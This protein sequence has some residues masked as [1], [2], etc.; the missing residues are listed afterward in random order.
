MHLSW[1][2]AALVGSLH[3]LLTSRQP[4]IRT[5]KFLLRPNTT[6]LRIDTFVVLLT[7]LLALNL[8]PVLLRPGDFIQDDSYFYLQ[9]ASHIV[10]GHGSTFHEITPTNGYHPLWM[11]CVV[12]MT[13]L[14]GGDNVWAVYLVVFLA[15]LLIAATLLLFRRLADEM[16][17][18]FWLPGLVVFASYLLGTGLYASEAHLNALTLVTATLALWRA[19]SSDG[20]RGWLLSGF[21][22]GV[23]ILA[24][25]DN[26]FVAGALIGFALW[27]DGPRDIA[28]VTRRAL[29]VGIG[30][31]AVLAP[32]LADNFLTY[33]HLV[34]ISGA[35]KSQLPTITFDLERLGP[36]GKLA[37]PFGLACLAIGMWL[38]TDRRRRF[39]WLG[40]GAGVVLHALYI[41]A[42]TDHY[43]FWAWYYVSA[44]VAASLAA[45]FLTEWFAARVG[46]VI[47]DKATR[48]LVA[49]SACVLLAAF[50]ARAWLKAFGPIHVAPLAVDIRINEYR[51]PEEFARW[52]KAHMPPGSIVF[53]Q[54]WPG[55]IAYYS[56]VPIVPMD[57]LVN[58]FRYN[59]ELLAL[60]VDAYLCR[61][62]IGYFLGHLRDP[63]EQHEVPVSAPLYRRAAGVLTLR[64]ERLFVETRAV[65]ERSEEAPPF[66]I[67]R[68]GCP[69]A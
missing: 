61:H 13:A 37:T 41:V 24:R 60:G 58:D 43:T 54:D 21:L 68:I 5:M 36:M 65:L 29:R 27:D 50:T 18:R 66:A 64:P 56:D 2:A 47:G 57:G 10:A 4:A 19:R 45:S 53:A 32:Y 46:P 15:L 12:A 62:G 28:R 40:L 48:R 63:A 11:A 69:G 35:I 17:L 44:V 20:D 49:I 26:I 67:W 52:M 7:T 31:A 9:I 3:R 39:L 38:D 16:A 14:A 6:V 51:W 1:R 59:D 25:L 34:P 33:G 23:A 22:F 55:A 8:V 42:C 30:L